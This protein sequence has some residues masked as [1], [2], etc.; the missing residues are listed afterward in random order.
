KTYGDISSTDLDFKE[1][2]ITQALSAAEAANAIFT[3]VRE[4]TSSTVGPEFACPYCWGPA[5]APCILL[6]IGEH[7]LW[8]SFI[9]CS[10]SSFSASVLL[11]SHF[12]ASSHSFRAVCL[13]CSLN[14]SPASSSACFTLKMYDSSWLRADTL[15]RWR[16]SSSLYR[17][18]S[19]NIL[20]IS[21][22]DKRPLS[23][24]IT[25]FLLRPVL[26]SLAD[27]FRIPF[28]SRSKV[29]SILGTPRGAGGMPVKSKRPS[30]LLSFVM[31]RSPSYTWMVTAGWL[32]EYVV[33]VCDCLQ[34]ILAL[35]SMILVITPPAVS[36]PSDRG[37]TSTNSTSWILECCSPLSIAACT[38]APYATASSGLM[39][40]FSCL[41]QKKF[42]NMLWILGMRVEPPTS[43]TSWMELLSSLASLSAFS[44]GSRV[45]RNRSAFSSSNRARDTLV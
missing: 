13:S 11:S 17:S 29:T 26:F 33:N 7:V 38:A 22:C 14:L 31:A 3:S 5:P 24:L 19:D 20:S 23:F 4:S 16:S 28:A 12:S 42:C 44:T 30:K 25:M 39:D 9:L 10:Y 37:A 34:G 8:S 32:S 15:C 35:R 40:R 45:P 36:I 2:L 41:P 43:T 21:A 27:T 6:M 1:F 18:A